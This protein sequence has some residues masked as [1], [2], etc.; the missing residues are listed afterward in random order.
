MNTSEGIETDCYL[1]ELSINFEVF[2][3]PSALRPEGRN[4]LRIDP[5]RAFVPDPKSMTWRSRGDNQKYAPLIRERRHH[6][7]QVTKICF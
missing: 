4:L 7:N 6:L 5:E 2:V 3:N 1:K